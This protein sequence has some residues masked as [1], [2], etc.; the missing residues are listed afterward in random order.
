MDENII[1][2]K[3]NIIIILVLIL[4]IFG[5]CG[6]IIYDKF[7]SNSK[8]D[9]LEQM[10]NISNEE[11]KEENDVIDEDVK[12][13]L[14][15]LIGL[16]ENGLERTYDEYCENLGNNEKCVDFNHI[17][18]ASIFINLGNGVINPNDIDDN[19]K[20]EIIF[21][22]TVSEFQDYMDKVSSESDDH[23]CAVGATFCYG[24]TQ[25]NFAKIA[26]RY[27]FSQNGMDLF[28]NQEID[29]GYYLYRPHAYAI[30]PNKVTDKLMFELNDDNSIDIIYNIKA[31]LSE[32]NNKFYNK[33]D[34]EKEIIYTFK[35][36]NNE[37]DLF[38]IKVVNK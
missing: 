20:K 9:N 12:K 26:K 15:S 37:Y 13:E 2:K 6:Y 3:N 23:Y 29:Q 19:L 27:G 34:Y 25:N 24:L 8:I 30:D 28:D 33:Q 38:Q 22:T 14:L 5:L 32:I 18:N 36:N 21:T 16:T 11:K 4:I 31:D 17:G 35:I 7:V 10:D 1:N